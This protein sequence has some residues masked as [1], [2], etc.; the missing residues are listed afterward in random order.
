MTLL[1]GRPKVTDSKDLLFYEYVWVVT[2]LGLRD[3]LPESEEDVPGGRGPAILIKS[4]GRER[5]G[6]KVYRTDRKPVALS[7][8]KALATDEGWRSRV[9]KEEEEFDDLVMGKQKVR[10]HYPAA[11]DERHLWEAL[12]RARTPAQVRR[13]CRRSKHWL[14]WEW[15]EGRAQIISP[16]A[17]PRALY[18]HA[19]EFCQSKRDPRFPRHDERPSGDYRRIEYF[20]RVMAGLS[21]VRPIAPSYSVDFLRKMKHAKDCVCWRCTLRIAPR[22]RLSLTQFLMRTATTD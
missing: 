8:H 2:F 18:D 15:K 21:L 16:S 3:G 6:L 4:S 20:A 10:M 19:E 22:Y 1:R 9:Q 11:P 12:K 13:I 7:I 5:E 14:R 17:C